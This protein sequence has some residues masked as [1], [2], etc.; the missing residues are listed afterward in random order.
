MN[1]F[2]L[3]FDVDW[4][5]D[6]AIRKIA[7]VL[8]EKKVK[9]TW[10]ITHDSKAIDELREQPELFEL[11]IHPNLLAGSTHGKTEEQVLDHVLKIVPGAISMRTHGL[12]QTSN[13]L[14]KA[15]D[16]GISIDVSLFL[17]RAAGLCPHQYRL[18]H[19]RLWRVPYFWEDD[20]EMF[21]PEPIWDLSDKRLYVDGLKIFDFHPIHILLNT[22]VFSKYK[23]LT[24]IKSLECWDEDF[25]KT[26]TNSDDPGPETLFMQLVEKL[27]AQGRKISDI[28]KQ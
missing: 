5:P 20:M 25:I 23:Q 21:E 8:I 18:Q 22:I 28:V 10:F 26:H 4:A 1:D 11:G 12:F 19:S 2:I 27:S 6:W 13:F 9:S 24:K 17:P 16:R 7:Q 15:Y 3:T 14:L